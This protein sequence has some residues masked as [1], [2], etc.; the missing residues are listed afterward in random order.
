MLLQP[1]CKKEQQNRASNPAFAANAEYNPRQWF[2][3]LNA[4]HS[5]G[6]LRKWCHHHKPILSW[7]CTN[8]FDLKRSSTGSAKHIFWVTAQLTANSN[9]ESG[10]MQ[11]VPRAKMFEVE[12]EQ[13]WPV[14]FCRGQTVK[15]RPEAEYSEL[16]DILSGISF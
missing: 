4:H 15:N 6:A 14:T 8:A 10:E 13:E 1:G 16:N 11:K 2:A 7:A 3:G 5:F 12:D 9:A